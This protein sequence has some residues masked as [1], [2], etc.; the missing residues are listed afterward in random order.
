M[1]LGKVDLLEAAFLPSLATK[2]PL[3]DI[4][5]LKLVTATVLTRVFRRPGKVISLELPSA[6]DTILERLDRRKLA[7]LNLLTG[8]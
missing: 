2:G 8:H 6:A 3:I 7:E 5:E 1:D 4:K